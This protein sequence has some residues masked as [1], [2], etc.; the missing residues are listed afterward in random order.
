MNA[1]GRINYGFL[2][3][4]IGLTASGAFLVIIFLHG[5]N[6]Q[7]KTTPSEPS[8]STSVT[9]SATQPSKLLKSKALLDSRVKAFSK[10]YYSYNPTESA[11]ELKHEIAPFTTKHFLKTASFGYGSSAAQQALLKEH[12]TILAT[13][14]SGL[15][16]DGFTP[17]RATGTVAIQISKK[18]DNGT[19]VSGTT[20]QSMTWVKQ[21]NTWLVDE[22]PLT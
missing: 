7:Q 2:W 14:T 20:E 18:D 11:A 9:A 4:I 21:G 10:L 6:K 5:G 12:A 13:A 1:R 16:G 22:A 17:R 19:V 3:A 15:E 8:A